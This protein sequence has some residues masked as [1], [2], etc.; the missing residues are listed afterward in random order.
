MH[1]HPLKHPGPPHG[2]TLLEL[3]V[4]IVL[5]GILSAT[6][7]PA[8]HGTYEAEILHAQS[9]RLTEAL[10]LAYSR[11]ITL[12]QPHRLHLNTN[13]G[14]FFIE[15]RTT[16]PDGT[17]TFNAIPYAPGAQGNLDPR[18]TIRR[19]TPPQTQ[20]SPEEP[21]PQPPLLQQPITFFPNGTAD[22]TLLIL[23]DRHGF[24]R[25]LRVN[26]ITARVDSPDLPPP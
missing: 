24:Q 14:K 20:A 26:P 17:T 21:N 19:S 10:N 13:E 6:L 16:S 9:R 3:M 4:V 23:H 12:N 1:H 25:A 22:A 15:G 18:I 7:I 11:A 2:F 5:I 8:M